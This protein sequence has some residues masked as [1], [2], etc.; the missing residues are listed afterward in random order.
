MP[1]KITV[2]ISEE[3]YDA[4]EKERKRLKLS[5]IQDVA[6]YVFAE[7]FKNKVEKSI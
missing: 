1:K 5:N 6:R 3:M 2:A 4:L 7:Y